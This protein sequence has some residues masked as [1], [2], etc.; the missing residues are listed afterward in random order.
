MATGYDGKR[1]RKS[2][3]RR[4]LRARLDLA[5]AQ[6]AELRPVA[7]IGIRY[8]DEI[9]APNIKEPFSIINRRADL[10]DAVRRYKGRRNVKPAALPVSQSQEIRP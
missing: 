10:V 5:E 9:Y 6:L 1:L 2:L 8:V 7:L 4:Q 3:T